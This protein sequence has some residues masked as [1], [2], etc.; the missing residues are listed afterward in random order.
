M[1]WDM[2]LDKLSGACEAMKQSVIRDEPIP[3]HYCDNEPE[4]DILDD[5]HSDELYEA[6]ITNQLQDEALEDSVIL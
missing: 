4:T 6:M 2:Y 3:S 1:T 5:D